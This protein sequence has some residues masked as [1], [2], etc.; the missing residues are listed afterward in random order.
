MQA[1]IKKYANN[2]APEQPHSEMLHA[3]IILDENEDYDGVNNIA[4]DF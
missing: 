1:I 4:E 3:F 2:I